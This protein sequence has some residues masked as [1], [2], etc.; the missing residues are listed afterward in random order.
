MKSS[1]DLPE[2]SLS[3]ALEKGLADALSREYES[4]AKELNCGI[5][6][7]EKANGLSV[8]VLSNVEKNHYVGD[9]VSGRSSSE[10]EF[11]ENSIGLT[12][13]VQMVQYYGD[14]GCPSLFPVRTKCI[15]LFQTIHG[16]DTLLFALYV[17]EYG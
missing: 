10:L 12:F 16:V 4:R 1:R 9:E 15:A 8:R 3:R 11:K 7:V 6:E 14:K 5:E 13:I 17:Y 2:S